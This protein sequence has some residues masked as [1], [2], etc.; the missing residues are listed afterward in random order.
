MIGRLDTIAAGGLRGNT[1]LR[2]EG[3]G[4]AKTPREMAALSQIN[5]LGRFC[6]RTGADAGMGF[7]HSGAPVRSTA[8]KVL[9]HASQG[10][11]PPSLIRKLTATSS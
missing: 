4:G 5:I 9:T 8:S 7:D 1:A 2:G 10:L 3:R 6:N 11:N